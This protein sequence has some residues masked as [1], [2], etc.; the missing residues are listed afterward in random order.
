MPTTAR[1]VDF[2]LEK[3]LTSAEF[4]RA[5]RMARFLR[6]VVEETVAGRSDELKERQI[7]IEVFERP[8][9]WDPKID[10][11][12]RSEA[13]RLRS[14]L[15]A[16]Y[17]TAGHDD[18]IKIYMPKGSY[19]VEF[20]ETAPAP[21]SEILP[22]LAGIPPVTANAQR[23]HWGL[24][25]GV[26]CV[27]LLLLISAFLLLRRHAYLQSKE[28]GFEVKPFAN[29]IGQEFSPAISPNGERIAYTWDGNKDNYDIYVKDVSRGTVTRL[30]KDP[31]PD[32]NPT[33]SPDGS[34]LAFLRIAGDRAHV[35]VHDL[36]T[37]EEKLVTETQSPLSTWLA[38]SNPYFGCHG[39]AWSPDGER[40]VVADQQA[41]GRG[42]G[43]TS[44]SVITGARS[45][46]TT[47]PGVERDTCPRFSPDGRSIAFVRYLSHGI[48]EVHIMNADGSGQKQLTG[49][50]RTI[51]G[52]DWAADG[53]EV[54]F[55]SLRQGS[56]QLRAID[57][58][59][60]ES[61]LVP[62]STTSA[63]DPS[64]ARKDSWLAFTEL[65]ENW[66]IWRAR[67][68]PGGLGKPELLLSST[69]KNHS[70]SYSPDGRQIA[71]VSDRSGS[72]ELWLADQNGA[73]LKRLTNFNG[74]WLGSIRWSPDGKTLA[75]DAR[76]AG[77]SGIFTMP[78]SGGVPVPLQQ[79]SFEERRPTWSHDGRSIYFNSNRGGTLQIWK[80]DLATGR[81][82][83]VGPPDTNESAESDD[84]Q[85]LVFTTNDGYALWRCRA[86]GAGAE[87]LLTGLHPEPGLDWSLAHDGVYFAGNQAEQ[88]GIFFYRFADHTT[89]RVGE[90]EKLLAPGTPSLSVSPDGQWLLY[91][92]LDHVSSDIKIRSARE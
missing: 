85:W 25:T 79:D 3:V 18:P 40:I 48:S 11:I 30:T 69:G 15:D 54:L 42:F 59:G 55:S 31:G 19:A 52:V 17:N 26:T 28:D 60:G 7:G 78:V 46:L 63:V 88:A 90:P 91:A 44:V 34:K 80:Q 82:Q 66:N 9:E 38:D 39:P 70:P 5:K 67:V 36:A 56:F 41:A 75:F 23:T 50:R 4:A 68:L 35:L 64:V 89:R 74:P 16:Y 22:A 86:D 33:W 43:L 8:T 21:Q 32:L 24:M 76:P 72:P 84:G 51:R 45:Q 14:K 1:A 29:E 2:Y 47:P 65:E 10:N 27:A 20:S 81:L 37:G 83:P 87:R 57:R 13:R 58:T 62:V 61:H 71:F 53:R 77:H 73:N 12:V 6:F 92:Q 49:D